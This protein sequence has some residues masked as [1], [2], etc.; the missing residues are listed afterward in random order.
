MIMIGRRSES[1]TFDFN[2]PRHSARKH[3]TELA[4]PR[5]NAKSVR[6]TAASGAADSTPADLDASSSL[7]A[8]LVVSLAAADAAAS[9]HAEGAAAGAATLKSLAGSISLVAA[10]SGG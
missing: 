5:S 6:C 7:V 4:P 8:S 2:R 10:G 9:G 1:S 3:R